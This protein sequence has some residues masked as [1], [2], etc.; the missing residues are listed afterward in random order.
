RRY[1]GFSNT[2]EG[3]S[4][5]GSSLSVLQQEYSSER[6]EFYRKISLSPRRYSSSTSMIKDPFPGPR[7]CA[8]SAIRPFSEQTSRHVYGSGGGG[9]F[10]GEVYKDSWGDGYNVNGVKKR[11]FLVQWVWNPVKRRC[12]G[13][14]AMD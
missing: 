14:N 13:P 7:N 6:F 12:F 4:Q 10:V 1:V 2:S 9:G 3:L 5:L 8:I 11:R